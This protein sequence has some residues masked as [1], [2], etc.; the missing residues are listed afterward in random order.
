[1]R[2][3]KQL[4]SGSFFNDPKVHMHESFSSVCLFDMEERK[5]EIKKEEN[6]SLEGFDEPSGLRVSG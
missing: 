5:R 6:C 3:K 1:M 4:C 2:V